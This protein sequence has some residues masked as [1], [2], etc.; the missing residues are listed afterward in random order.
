MA[1]FCR[2]EATSYNYILHVV[3]PYILPSDMMISALSA[4]YR[5]SEN[6]FFVLRYRKNS[7]FVVAVLREF[8]CELVVEKQSVLAISILP[9]V[10]SSNL[11]LNILA[12]PQVENRSCRM[13]YP[14][15]QQTKSSYIWFIYLCTNR[16]PRLT[17][18][19]WS[20]IKSSCSYPIIHQYISIEQSFRNTMDQT[21]N[22]RKKTL[23]KSNYTLYILEM[24]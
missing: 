4:A 1:R 18:G 5:S 13:Y 21:K 17:Q 12:I 8:V 10:N 14:W 24:I 22:R 9:A 6:F 11:I 20:I 7:T 19:T 3:C 15:I 2:R 16:D 23:T